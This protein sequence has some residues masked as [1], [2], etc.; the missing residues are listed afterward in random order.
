[1]T[2]STRIRAPAYAALVMTLLTTLPAAMPARA[3]E[4]E[5]DRAPPVWE[6]G[7]GITA[8]TLPDYRGSDKSRSYLL[9]LPYLVY[10]SP[11]LNLDRSGLRAELL[12]RGR[13]EL[14]FSINLSVPVR[15]DDNPTRAGMPRLR[16]ALEFGPQLKSDLWRSEDRR[17]RLQ[18]QLPL[19]YGM[20]LS[21]SSRN[22]GFVFHPRLAWDLR[23]FAGLPGWNVGFIAGPLFATARFHD[24]FYTVDPQYA[25]AN[26]P[27]YRAGGGYSGMQW[28]VA[29]SKRFARHWFGG[30]ARIDQVGGATFADSPLVR[31]R[32]NVSA[33]VAFTWIFAESAE[34]AARRPSQFPAGR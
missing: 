27:A 12:D 13:L 20:T 2:I 6:A 8:L 30:F 7:L 29:V 18:L 31:K 33:G 34:R 1:M 11:R 26:R 14:D 17:Q 23:D 21:G 28:T 5:D 25:T 4:I 10:R 15:S 32:T 22:V 16:P 3:D 9:P 19:R 24:Y